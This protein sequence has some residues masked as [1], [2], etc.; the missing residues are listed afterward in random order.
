MKKLIK[1]YRANTLSPQDLKNLRQQMAETDDEQLAVLME[2][3]WLD[4]DADLTL[5]DPARLEA[6]RHRLSNETRATKAKGRYYTLYNNVTS[7]MK[8]AA[9]LLIPLLMAS[10][11]FFYIK[12]QTQL[13]EE[14]VVV[15]G[16]GESATVRLP[17]GSR[18]TLFYESHLGYRQ[19]SFNTDERKVNF[20]GEAHFKV[21]RD[22][23]HPFVV[24]NKH[25]EVTVLGTE[26][27]LAARHTDSMACLYLEEGS[28]SL[29]SPSSG[30]TITM[31]PRDHATVDY[32]T[33]KITVVRMLSKPLTI[34]QGYL[35]FES[36]PLSK[37]VN[38]LESN[39]GCNIIVADKSLLPKAFSGSLPA[40]NINEALE[41]LCLSFEIS[42]S[43]TGNTYTLI[44]NYG[45]E[46]K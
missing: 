34:A 25:L 46:T 3:D 18:V 17:D 36:T 9:V 32:A 23:K 26:F 20:D 39:F 28:V 44:K 8:Y 10:T 45:T 14:T 33:G 6:V 38:T 16:K 11:V 24:S 4:A 37:V 1:K 29:C 19:S 13:T 12:S 40:K 22:R 42:V 7:I 27:S 5:A 31:E 30:Q 21:R 35:S 43:R 41:V 15:T 2:D